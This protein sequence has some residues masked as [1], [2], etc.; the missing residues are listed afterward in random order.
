MQTLKLLFESRNYEGLKKVLAENPALANQGIAYDEQNSTKA[1]PLHRLCDGVFNKNFSD[2]DA[3]EMAK[4]LLDNGANVNG[5]V[6]EEK[7]DTPLIAAASLFAEQVGLLYIDRGANIHHAGTH[8]GTALH[9]AASLGRDRLVQRLIDEKAEINKRC[10]DFQGTPL[11]WAVH[12]YKFHNGRNV[13][14]QSECVKLLVEAGA[15]KTIPNKEG[16]QPIDFLEEKDEEIL[17][18]LR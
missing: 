11:L 9:W 7:K 14:H 4:I 3:V 10:I 17:R 6:S 1:H 5:Q 2:E 15:D 8:G 12:G 16:R 18:L 13:Y